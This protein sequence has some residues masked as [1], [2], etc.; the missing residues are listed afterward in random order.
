MIDLYYWGR[1]KPTLNLGEAFIPFLLSRL[2]VGTSCNARSVLLMIGSELHAKTVEDLRQRYT[3]IV[4]WGYGY[5]HGTPPDPSLL[6]VRA[7]RGTKTAA[8]L[9]LDN[10]VVG[11]PGLLLP[12]Y[13]QVPVTGDG[14][15]LLAPH[16]LSR[17]LYRGRSN[18]FD[19]ETT[20]RE[21]PVKISE[22]AAANF[23]LTSSLHV[24]LVC[25]AY[26]IPFSPF[27]V[28]GESPDKPRKWEDA[29]SVLGI[30]PRW[31][32][33]EKEA[34]AWYESVRSAIYLPD[35]DRLLDAFPYDIAGKGVAV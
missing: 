1:G 21:V 33:T 24:S 6:D 13:L 17:R 8:V 7:V 27:L 3:R 31:S 14:P 25:I 18:V 28:A 29:Y 23:V 11:D 19:V 5:S 2:G 20:I 30:I 4:V 34:R 26:G 35:L 10:P 15:T 16:F 12:R 22:L 9:G 32:A